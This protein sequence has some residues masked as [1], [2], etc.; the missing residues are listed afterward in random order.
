MH[1][2]YIIVKLPMTDNDKVGGF[3]SSL[4]LLL[5]KMTIKNHFIPDEVK[6]AIT[7]MIMS[8]ILR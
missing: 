4:E 7:M 6:K 8:K 3:S 5:L 1:G 2:N